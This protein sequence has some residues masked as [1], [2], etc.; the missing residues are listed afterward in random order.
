MT[1]RL[2]LASALS[3]ALLAVPSASSA[4]GRNLDTASPDG[5][6]FAGELAAETAPAIFRLSLPARQGIE[7]EALPVGSSDPQIKVFEGDSRTPLA[8]N[9]DRPGT[10]AARVRLWSET[11][12][13]VRVEVSSS[14]SGPELAPGARFRLV[15]LPTDY[16]P[17]APQ[18]IA[19][20]ATLAGELEAGDERLFHFQ[21]EAGQVWVFALAAP[22]P[23]PL[24]PVLDV[25]AGRTATGEVLGNDDDGGGDLDAR[26]RF[27]VPRTGPY[28][29][30]AT[31]AGNSG[32]YQLSATIQDAAAAPA[33]NPV[34]ELDR[35]QA[36]TFSD[37]APERLYRLSPAAR[38][39]FAQG[40]SLTIRMTPAADSEVDPL[41]EAGFETPL[42]F[43]AAARDDDGGGALAAR[44]VIDLTGVDAAWLERLRIRASSVGSDFGAYEI[45]ISQD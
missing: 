29:L 28:T 14:P 15:V 11:A 26:L 3:S 2:L 24:D 19:P 8:E 31:S 17:V 36:G 34:L 4:Q 22:E 37:E 6:V 27:R 40:G 1:A 45:T 23:S 44:L 18:A 10:V 42:G 32:A 33:P 16:R 20:G 25:F 7:L 13:S 38:A 5:K 30:R 9:D 21:G 43:S 35:A 39:R 12:K 41:V